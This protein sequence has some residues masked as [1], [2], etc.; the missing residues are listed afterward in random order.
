MPEIRCCRI[1][2]AELQASTTK[3]AQRHF[4]PFYLRQMPLPG[5]SLTQFLLSVD[6]LFS[7]APFDLQIKPLRLEL[8]LQPGIF[9]QMWNCILD[10]MYEKHCVSSEERIIPVVWGWE[11]APVLIHVTLVSI[12]SSSIKAEGIIRV[13]SWRCFV[14]PHSV[15]VTVYNPKWLRKCSMC[16]AKHRRC[17]RA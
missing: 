8:C 9:R 6:I 17:F 11:K 3:A 5:Q 7:I 15:S 13:K 14:V 1:K 12:R 10:V 4:P 2:V 16:Q